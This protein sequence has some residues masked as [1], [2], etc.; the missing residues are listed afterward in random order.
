[1]SLI[2]R[3]AVPGWR[4]GRGQCLCGAAPVLLNHVGGGRGARC[5]VRGPSCPASALT[6]ARLVISHSTELP[7]WQPYMGLGVDW[8][9]A[10]W[11]GSVPC[12]VMLTSLSPLQ[13]C[14]QGME[15]STRR[16]CRE[17]DVNRYSLQDLCVVSDLTFMSFFFFFWKGV[18]LSSSKNI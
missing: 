3:V 5:G 7:P 11:L 9:P 10:C 14:P 12:G 17:R 15:P 2:A 8:G 6:G 4:G 1:M 16:V 13:T 18:F